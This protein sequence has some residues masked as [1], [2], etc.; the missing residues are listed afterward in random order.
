[1]TNVPPATRICRSNRTMRVR[2]CSRLNTNT[3]VKKR[4]C[5][6][7]KTARRKILVVPK[8]TMRHTRARFYFYP[9]YFA[10]AYIS[11]GFTIDLKTSFEPA[12]IVHQRLQRNTTSGAIHICIWFSQFRC[13]AS[14][15]KTSYRHKFRNV[16]LHFCEFLKHY[17]NIVKNK[18]T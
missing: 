16:F 6:P 11:R 8:T 15:S 3:Y 18:L 5:K 13:N 14:L 9:P 7:S 10:G 4:R 12:P 2:D 17:R 1:M